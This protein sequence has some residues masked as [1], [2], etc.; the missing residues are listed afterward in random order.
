MSPN[1]SLLLLGC[2]I[3]LQPLPAISFIAVLSSRS[4]TRAGWA[5]LAG[6]I[7]SLLCV[8]AVAVII[9]ATT[10]GSGFTRTSTPGRATYIA[11]LLLGLFLIVLG[12]RRLRGGP[13]PPSGP[14]KLLQRLEALSLPV[15]A[16]IG[17]LIQPWT[18]LIAGDLAIL[19]ADLHQQTTLVALGLF[20]VVGTAGILGMEIYAIA[21]PERAED[22][23]GVLRSWLESH[24]SVILTWLAL[25]VG[26]WLA[27]GGIMGLF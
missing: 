21:A 17:A 3:A 22:R 20:C 12:L 25:V 23:L 6:W 5:F 26:A 19:T 2:F 10:G 9:V 4:R 7:A 13:P 1:A 15:A 24:Q 27:L 8:V 14:P 11:Q 16:L 18:L